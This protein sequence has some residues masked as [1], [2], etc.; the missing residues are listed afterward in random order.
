MTWAVADTITLLGHLARQQG[1]YK[2]AKLRYRESLELYRTLD[3][4]HTAWCLEGVAA[5]LCAEQR[6]AY[7]VRLC[8][9]AVMLRAVAHTPLPRTEQQDFDMVVRTARA[10]L[11][12]AVFEQEWKTGSMMG[13]D[14]AIF[15]AL[16]VLPATSSSMGQAH[17]GAEA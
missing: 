4:T 7:A 11:D 13:K 3:S 5:L 1:D 12:E 9:A 16:H 2:R 14:E 8:A 10:E 15:Y 17:N 6:Y